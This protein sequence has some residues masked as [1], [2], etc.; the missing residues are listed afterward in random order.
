MAGETE[1]HDLIGKVASGDRAALRSVFV[2][3]APRL[4]GVA[5]VILRERTLAADA[6]Q[7]AFVRI[8]AEAHGFDPARVHA[9]AW[10]AGHVRQSALDLARL[11]G[12]ESTADELSAPEAMID[13]DA[14]DAL[15]ATEAGRALRERLA[16]LD[17]P[18][19]RAVVLAFVHGL[20]HAELAGILGEPT[21]AARTTLWRALLALR[22]A[23]A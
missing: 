21:A 9:E 19:R 23:R 7:N 13:P 15:V 4:F 6:L 8:W 1:L 11:N 5:L 22:E 18:Q 16:A 20:S 10:L 12:R 14:L 3:T 2:R 17:P